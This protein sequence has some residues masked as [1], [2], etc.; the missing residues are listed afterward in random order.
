MSLSKNDLLDF[1]AKQLVKPDLRETDNF[2]EIGITA[3][4]EG[5]IALFIEQHFGICIDEKAIQDHPVV[6]D[7]IDYVIN[8]A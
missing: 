5:L 4:D 2:R 7:F 6:S 8:C 3:W 1:L